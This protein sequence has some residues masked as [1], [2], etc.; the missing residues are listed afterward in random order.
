[1]T[2][3]AKPRVDF[4]EE[5]KKRRYHTCMCSAEHRGNYRNSLT[6]TL[7]YRLDISTQNSV[8]PTA[9]SNIIPLSKRLS[10]GCYAPSKI[11]SGVEMSQNVTLCDD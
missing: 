2:L 5:G 9:Y 4:A 3:G 1:M 6:H 8:S 7:D 10:I 11:S